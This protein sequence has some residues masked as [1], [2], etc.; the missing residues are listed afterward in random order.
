MLVVLYMFAWIMACKFCMD[1]GRSQIR[2]TAVGLGIFAFLL[3]WLL[4]HSMLSPAQAVILFLPPALVQIGLTYISLRVFNRVSDS[5]LM[6]L[7]VFAL[8]TALQ[9]F[10]LIAVWGLWLEWWY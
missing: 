7:I 5:I 3:M 2:W 6:A 10:C 1:A 9:L 8:T 4:N